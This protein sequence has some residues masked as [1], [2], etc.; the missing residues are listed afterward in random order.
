MA[1]SFVGELMDLL[2]EETELYQKVPSWICPLLLDLC[3]SLV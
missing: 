2:E 1:H 3:L